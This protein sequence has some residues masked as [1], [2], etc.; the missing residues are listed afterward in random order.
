MADISDLTAKQ[1]RGLFGRQRIDEEARPPLE[2][3]THLNANPDLQVPMVPGFR[4]PEE[5]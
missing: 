5:G 4:E 3:P 2:S 1:P